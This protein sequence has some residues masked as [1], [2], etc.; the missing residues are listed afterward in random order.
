MAWE[1]RLWKEDMKEIHSDC[2][3]CI[4][5]NICQHQDEHEAYVYIINNLIKEESFSLFKAG[6]K[7]VQFSFIK[8]PK[9][10]QCCNTYDGW[11][12]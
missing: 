1:S 6:F 7:C 2:K 9:E 5:V 3:K 11:G 8:K 4:H 12:L 10:S